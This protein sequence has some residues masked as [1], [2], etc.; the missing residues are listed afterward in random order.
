MRALP[1]GFAMRSLNRLAVAAALVAAIGSAGCGHPGARGSRGADSTE[2]A[3]SPERRRSQAFIDAGNQAYQSG[4]FELAL[5]R[6]AAAAVADPRDPAAYFG[7]GMTFTRLKRE[8]EARAA[9]AR[10]RRLAQES[11]AR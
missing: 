1:R 9:F 3:A 2:V 8:D 4:D 5:K 7:M 11:G 6:Y 10:A